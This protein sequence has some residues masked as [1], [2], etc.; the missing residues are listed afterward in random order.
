MSLT[1]AGAEPQPSLAWQFE[2]SNVDYVTNR[3]PVFSTTNTTTTY[4]PTYQTGKYNLGMRLQNNT[5][6]QANTWV[7]YTFSTPIAADSGVSLSCWVKYTTLTSTSSAIATLYDNIV[8]GF[9]NTMSI[10]MTTTSTIGYYNTGSFYNSN[11]V[12]NS[13]SGTY[14]ANIWYHLTV[15]F[16][17]TSIIGYLNGVASTSK[18][19]LTTGVSFVGLRLG[20][21]VNSF[22]DNSG[23]AVSDCTIDDLRIYNR[24]LSPTQV[25]SVWSQGAAPAS[26]FITPPSLTYSW[27]FENSNV[28]SES[29]LSPSSSSGPVTYSAGKWQQAVN[30]D[31]N[32]TGTTPTQLL[33]YPVSIG[34]ANGFSVSYWINVTTLNASN[35]QWAFQL[36]GAGNLSFRIWVGAGTPTTT[37]NQYWQA[38]SG[39]TQALFQTLVASSIPI[40][41]AQWVH[42][43]WTY[44]PG[45]GYQQYFNGVFNSSS[46]LNFNGSSVTSDGATPSTIT[47]TAP[48][49]IISV[50]KIGWAFVFGWTGTITGMTN[51]QTWVINSIP[52]STTFTFIASGL[53]SAISTTANDF[54]VVNQTDLTPTFTTMTLGGSTNTAFNGLFDDLRIYNAPLTAVQAEDIYRTQGMPSKIDLSALGYTNIT[55]PTLYSFSSQVFSNAQAT[56]NIGPTQTQLDATY[57]TLSPTYLTSNVGVQT[58]TVPLTGVYKIEVAGASGGTAS[59]VPSGGGAAGRGVIISCQGVFEK[60]QTLS[61]IVGQQGVSAA[62]QNTSNVAGGGGG[63]SFVLDFSSQYLYIAAGGGGGASCPGTGQTTSSAGFDA[64]YTTNGTG[65]GGG[66]SGGTNGSGGTAITVGTTGQAGGAGGGFYSDGQDARSDSN[67]GAGGKAVLRTSSSQGGRSANVQNLTNSYGGFGCGGGGGGNLVLNISNGCGGGGGGGYSGGGGGIRNGRGGGGGGSFV[68]LDQTMTQLGYCTSNGYASVTY[69][70]PV[71]IRFS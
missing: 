17:S 38:I 43:I 67:A 10:G 39:T 29:G 5:G 63:G 25:R 3:S 35:R 19:T 53:V 37:I 57:P 66:T 2:T 70:Y 45:L 4:A 23:F 1:A 7:R 32:V 52:T 46:G 11:L 9:A 30:F 27:Q 68:A 20:T 65:G 40:S 34:G 44:R 28:D 71:G 51:N 16:N 55:A 61:I 18:E 36:S 49:N 54:T 58:W 14:S 69:L 21:Y 15:T 24:A 33:T 59:S 8:S 26:M 22:N 6:S 42:V 13:V 47:V 12:P 62:S 41:A 56:S 60:N 50:L 64:V 31:A 48:A